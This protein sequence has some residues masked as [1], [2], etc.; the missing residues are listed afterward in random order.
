[1]KPD[2]NGFTPLTG[3]ARSERAVIS[4]LIEPESA[5]ALRIEASKDGTLQV[6]CTRAVTLKL[7]PAINKGS[8]ANSRFTA[9]IN[10]I[11][12]A[13]DGTCVIS[14]IVQQDGLAFN[15]SVRGFQSSSPSSVCG[16]T[17]IAGRGSVASRSPES[18]S[19]SVEQVAA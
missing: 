15:I 11:A 16:S 1:M 2:H 10:E 7:D 3:A 12:L 9:S 6:A 13:E 19:R 18:L 14:A 4:V 17:T 5:D 8:A